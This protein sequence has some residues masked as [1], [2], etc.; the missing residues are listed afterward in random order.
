MFTNIKIRGIVLNPKEVNPAVESIQK[1]FVQMQAMSNNRI[2][3][4]D[5]IDN[6]AKAIYKLV[7]T[8]ASEYAQDFKK[9]AQIYKQ[10]SKLNRQL[11]TYESRTGNDIRDCYERFLAVEKF[12]AVYNDIT[13]KYHDA[14]EKV[15]DEMGREMY[16]QKQ[17]KYEQKKEALAAAVAKAKA[18]KKA[19]LEERKRAL[20]EFI[21]AREQYNIFKVRRLHHAFTTYSKVL[22]QYSEKEEQLFIQAQETLKTLKRNNAPQALNDA[23][24]DAPQPMDNSEIQDAL[25]G[26]A[27]GEETEIPIAPAED[28]ETP[29]RDDDGQQNNEIVDDI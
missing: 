11:A 6:Y 7:R 20:Q 4:A 27:P 13:D 21:N 23:L 18:N 3:Y 17:P 8:W 28:T 25:Q 15:I 9:Y 26:I 10:I 1:I 22:A 5:E 12:A 2:K 14:S 16:E 29:Y 19:L 24:D